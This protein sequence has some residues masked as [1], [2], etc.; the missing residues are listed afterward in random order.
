M[1]AYGAIRRPS[2][3]IK[4]PNEERSDWSNPG[5]LI[6]EGRQGAKRGERSDSQEAWRTSIESGAIR[7][8]CKAFS[9]EHGAIRCTARTQV[10]G[11]GA[12]RK[13]R[14]ASSVERRVK[15]VGSMGWTKQKAEQSAG[16]GESQV[17]SEE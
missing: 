9:V 13:R 12:I 5:G 6:R 2:R 15:S 4:S 10:A 3:S 14:R 1:S 11:S 8:R 17:S 7:E 16:S